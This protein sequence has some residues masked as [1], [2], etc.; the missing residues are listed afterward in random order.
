MSKLLHFTRSDG[1]SS[2]WPDKLDPTPFG[3]EVNYMKPIDLNESLSVRWRSTIGRE[4]AKLLG[5]KGIYTSTLAVLFN[6]TETTRRL[7]G[8]Y[9]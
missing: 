1:T 4:V 2:K 9:D 7:H 3:G 6:T 8:L 5:Y